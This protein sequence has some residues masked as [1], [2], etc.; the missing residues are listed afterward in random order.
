MC[1]LPGSG[2]PTRHP[3]PVAR[4][5]RKITIT[6]GSGY[7][8]QLLRRG[9]AEDGY[10]IDNFDR[11]RGPVIDLMRRRYLGTMKS[12]PARVAAR[13]IRA[14]QTRAEP[15]LI[16]SRLVRPGGDDILDDRDRIAARFAGSHA[17]IH[18]AAIPHPHLPGA[19]EEDFVRLNY[20]AAITVFEAAR[21][22][23]VANFV[24]ASSA[25]VYR[26][27]DPFRLAQ[28]PIVE[29]NY[30]PLPAEGQTTY[31]FLKAAVERYLAG[32]CDT[33]STQAVALRLEFPGVQSK[34]P[35]NLYVSTS[36]GNLV[37]GFSCALRPPS[38]LGF[39]VFNLA[40]AEVDPAIVDIQAYIRA[41]WPYVRNR[42][43]GNQC[44][45]GTEKAQRVLGYRPVR[46]GR[47]IDAGLLW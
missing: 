15:A 9:L 42:T 21:D 33:G 3:R 24:F 40:D 46:D 7:V 41:R 8:G 36:L 38:D 34:E 29:S 12:V 39:D 13:A 44:L 18:L 28:L 5:S 17:V 4:L 32:A 30:L 6:G 11:F 16:R 35:S 19:T 23:G 14:A 45:L 43:V 1:S 27:N 26:I 10:L 47:Y 20:D 31:G 25:Q 37:A 22:A 2:G